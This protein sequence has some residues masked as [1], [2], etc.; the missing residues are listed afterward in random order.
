MER[1]LHPA[2][3][4]YMFAYIFLLVMV[5]LGFSV[6]PMVDFGFGLFSPMALLVGGVFVLRDYVQRAAGHWVLLA[7]AIGLGLSYALAD[8]YVALAS[9]AAFAISEL[10]DYLIYSV[11]KR[12]FRDRV[13]L[14]SFISTPVDTFVFLALISGLTTGT[15]VLMV[16]SKL[17]A[18]AIVWLTNRQ[19]EREEAEEQELYS[20]QHH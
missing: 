14:S 3:L 9:A 2:S 8:P 6:V 17:A 13:L 12:P 16:L 4:G 11:T 5:N 7:M 10:T 20:T 18:A 15:F 1:L 19:L